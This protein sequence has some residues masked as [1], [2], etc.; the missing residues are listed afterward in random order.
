MTYYLRSCLHCGIV[1]TN[2]STVPTKELY[3]VYGLLLSAC[4]MKNESTSTIDTIQMP[5]VTKVSFPFK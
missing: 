1:G 5:V 3:R 2:M 4:S